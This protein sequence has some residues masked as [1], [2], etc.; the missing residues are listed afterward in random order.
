[1][2]GVSLVGVSQSEVGQTV[3]VT[4]TVRTV[5][6]QGGGDTLVHAYIVRVCVRAP[7][8]TGPRRR[9]GGGPNIY[10]R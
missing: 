4:V 8:H 1:M 10:L 2:R 7:W 5:S 3:T 9:G 6:A